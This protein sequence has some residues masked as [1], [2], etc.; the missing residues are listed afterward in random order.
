MVTVRAVRAEDAGVWLQLR[1]A[2]W[3]D[4]ADGHGEEIGRFFAGT[5]PREPWAVLLAEDDAGHA[6]GLIEL[7]I[8]PY[9]EGCASRAVAYVEGWFVIPEARRRGVGRAL[10]AA[11][12]SWGRSRG[13]TELASD[14]APENIISTAA[15]RGAGFTDAGT[16]RCFR[17]EL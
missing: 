6:L 11:A 5:F 8:R 16:V 17:K 13:C 1:T 2:L 14:T 7:S 9:A 3:P 12:E 4:G 10:M 15:I